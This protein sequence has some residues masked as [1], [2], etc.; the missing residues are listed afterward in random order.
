MIIT[1]DIARIAQ[2]LLKD[3]TGS[4]VE[5]TWQSLTPVHLT[6]GQMVHGEVMANFANSR[7][8]VRIANELLRM[9]IP[10]NLQPGQAVELTFVTEEPRLV[11]ALSKSG[12]SA[13]PVQISDTGR[14]LNTLAQGAGD[15]PSTAPLPRPSLVISGPP[16]D[17]ALLAEGLKNILTR[18]GVFYESHLAQWMRGERPLTDLLREPQGNLSPLASRLPADGTPTPP[19]APNAPAAQAPAPTST[20]PAV[21]ANV[22]PQEQ[23]GSPAASRPVLPQGAPTQQG[24]EPPAAGQVPPQGETLPGTDAAAG[25]PKGAQTPAAESRDPLPH[26]A[27]SPSPQNQPASPGRPVEPSALPPSQP[28]QA[29]GTSSPLPATTTGNAPPASSTQAPPTP[30]EAPQPKP[31]GEGTVGQTMTAPEREQTPQIRDALLPRPTG[32]ERPAPVPA[33]DARPTAENRPHPTLR[34][35]TP[36]TPSPGRPAAPPPLPGISE[37]GTRVVIPG[38]TG[39]VNRGGMGHPAAPPSPAGVEPQTIPLIREQL[40]TLTTGVFTWFGQVWPGQDMEWKVEERE[41]EGGKGERSWQTEVAVELP[42]LGAVRATL[43]SGKEGIVVTLA[44]E[45]GRTAEILTLRQDGLE[46]RFG[47]AGLR[48]GGFMV[49]DGTQ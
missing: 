15:M 5:A 9:E 23:A 6:P 13:T 40:T 4:L 19:S 20:A 46:E 33:P 47:A 17:P 8:L 43:R 39:P 12:N 11:F 48:L 18:S 27:T 2:A 31:A 3:T 35:G 32:G 38:E 36:T 26:A 29:G 16:R 45:D 25:T 14:W 21:P 10:L 42:N 49:R 22:L 28:H 7:Y 44:A 41:P 37:A 34:D 24:T 1:Q 30:A